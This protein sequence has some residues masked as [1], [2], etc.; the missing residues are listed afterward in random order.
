[1]F[2]D[3]LNEFLAE[4]YPTDV[5]PSQNRA[6]VE[7][8]SA[9]RVQAQVRGRKDRAEAKKQREGATKIQAAARGRNERKKAGLGAS[10]GKGR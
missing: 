3:E 6:A 7:H 10:S 8:C 9:S 5:A 1:M 4:Q 2:E